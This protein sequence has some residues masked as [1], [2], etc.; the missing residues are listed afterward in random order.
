MKRLL[1][2]CLMLFALPAKGAIFKVEAVESPPYLHATEVPVSLYSEYAQPIE[3]VDSIVVMFEYPA[4]YLG[5]ISARMQPG[6]PLD[7]WTVRGVETTG[8]T[9]ACPGNNR[10]VRITMTGEEAL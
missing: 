7:G 3:Y 8:Y 5:Y 1:F 9:P 10:Y 4:D 2:V 6:G